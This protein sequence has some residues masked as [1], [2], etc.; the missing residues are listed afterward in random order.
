MVAGKI[1]GHP[2]LIL[3]AGRGGTA[4]LEMFVEDELVEV[5]GIADSNLESP[6]IK[7]A[8]KHGIPCYA[9]AL[10][11]LQASKD[12]A[13]CIIYNLTHDDSIAQEA[14]AI[15]GSKKVTGG[16][17]AK[18][19]WQMVTNMKRMKSEL[20][21]SQDQLKA[22]IQHAMDGIITINELGE[23]QGFN[24]AAEEIFGYSQQEV[25]GKNVNILMAEPTRSE[26]D[27]RIGHYVSTGEGRIIGHRGREVVAVRKGGEQFPME[28]SASEMF[29]HGQRF[30]IGIIRDITERKLAEQKITHMAHHDF[31]TGLPNRILFFDRLKQAI[32]MAERGGQKGAVVFLDLDGF[33]GVNDQVGHDAGDLLLQ[34]VSRRLVGIV[35][36]SDTMARVGGDEFTFVLNNIGVAENV[37]AM[38][39]KMIAAL[40]EPFDLKGQ[41]CKIGG[42]IGISIFPDDSSEFGA[43][44]KQAD[45][46]MYL[47]K[48]C[49]KNTYQFYRDMPNCTS[50]QNLTK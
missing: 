29:L 43:L 33:K 42:S 12:Y 8:Q 16:P 44:L 36:A 50:V 14:V 1:H 38:A 24:P 21:K 30:F 26:H 41:Q 39:R 40:S 27:E 34:E 19:F 32:S 2:I 4:L 49:G 48:Q 20:L 25:M 37:A 7:L 10:E 6:G 35:R 3:G 31:L 28:L 15:L 11:A 17:E 46:A 18:L 9:N 13:D 22:V 5:V 47:A 45:E 23:I